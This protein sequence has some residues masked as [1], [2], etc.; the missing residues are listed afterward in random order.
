MRIRLVLSFLLVI[1]ITLAAVFLF[2]QQATTEQVRQFLGRGGM[3]GADQL[4][5]SLEAYYAEQGN[6]EGVSELFRPGRQGNGGGSGR[7]QP[8]GSGPYGSFSLLDPAGFVIYSSELGVGEAAPTALLETGIALHDINGTVQGYLVSSTGSS[9][10]DPNFEEAL[11]NII[12][13]ASFKAAWISGGIGLVLA[14][15]LAALLLRP[16]QN[17]TKAANQLA[18]G[19]LDTRVN[20][21]NPRE[22]AVLGETFN[23][24][25]QSLEDAEE[26]RKAMTADIAHELRTPLAVQRANLEAL[27]DGVF[28]LTQESITQILDQN[29]LLTRLVEDLRTLA[30]ADAGELRL[31]KRLTNIND[32]VFETVERFRAKAIEN[33]I[34]LQIEDSHHPIKITIDPERIQQVLYNLLQNGLRYTPSGGTI[35]IGIRSENEQTRIQITDSGPGIDPESLPHLFDRFYRADKARD[36]QRGGTGLGLTIARQLMKAHNGELTAGNTEGG[37]AVFTMIFPD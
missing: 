12:Q 8:S 2:A 3:M 21:E 25:A 36:R 26:T 17:L 20:V 18:K 15:I 1:S 35:R 10:A 33:D 28:P 22:M 23:Q 31:E 7:N 11:L 13:Q 9:A 34:K 14:L 4:V 24:M 37:G 16:I 30:L 32:L 19:N 6:W 29:L 27:Q 5:L